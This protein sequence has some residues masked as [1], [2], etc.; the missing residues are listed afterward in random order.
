MRCRSTVWAQVTRQPRSLDGQ[1]AGILCRGLVKLTSARIKVIR[2]SRVDT[3]DTRHRQRPTWLHAKTCRDARD[4]C[5]T[6]RLQDMRVDGRR[7]PVDPTGVVELSAA[8]VDAHGG[9]DLTTSPERAWLLGTSTKALQCAGRCS[10]GSSTISRSGGV[11]R[12]HAA[13]HPGVVAGAVTASKIKEGPG[14]PSR[15][16]TPRV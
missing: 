10:R 5:V 12:G 6:G 14:P 11:L 2:Q 9:S 1:L 7:R 4:R 16:T 3:A 8:T 13:E 15:A